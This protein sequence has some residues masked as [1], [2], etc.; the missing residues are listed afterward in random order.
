M[1]SRQQTPV[2][3]VLHGILKSP[4]ERTE[5]EAGGRETKRSVVGVVS[6]DGAAD[7]RVLTE[8]E[9]LSTLTLT[10][11]W[12]INNHRTI[13]M[14]N[15]TDGDLKWHLA[16][17][18]TL[19]GIRQTCV[20]SGEHTVDDLTYETHVLSA[21][22]SVHHISFSDLFQL[23]SWTNLLILWDCDT[24]FIY[25]F[26]SIKRFSLRVFFFSIGIHQK[27]T[28]CNRKKEE[29]KAPFHSSNIALA[30]EKQLF[31]IKKLELCVNRWRHERLNAS[32]MN[33]T[34][35]RTVYRLL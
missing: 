25:R 24:G 26:F 2:V 13:M 22:T 10:Q 7:R 11:L 4:Q 16:A 19:S 33:M 8:E 21:L 1:D 31:Y 32:C 18:S 35:Q 6:W 23:L 9:A 27:Q 15:S 28:C 17:W 30:L 34:P 3:A 14:K 5:M 12:E 20:F 29:M